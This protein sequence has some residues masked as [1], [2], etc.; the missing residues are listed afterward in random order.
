MILDHDNYW[1]CGDCGRQIPVTEDWCRRP[2]NDYLGMRGGSI[3]SAIKR[4]VERGMN[5]ILNKY[6][7]PDF[8]FMNDDRIIQDLKSRHNK[9]E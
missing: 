8:G 2:F 9:E 5:P 4:E 1:Y 3:E 7:K 6:A